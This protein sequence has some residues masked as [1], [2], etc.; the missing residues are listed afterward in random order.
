[1]KRRNV[2]K[3]RDLNLRKRWHRNLKGSNKIR[4]VRNR[5]KM[6]LME[7]LQKDKRHHRRKRDEIQIINTKKKR[8]AKSERNNHSKTKMMNT[9]LNKRISL[10]THP[11]TISQ[12]LFLKHHLSPRRRTLSMHLCQDYSTLIC[13]WKNSER[14]T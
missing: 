4:M 7:K 9:I 3:K 10:R 14:C 1:M 6:T 11:S 2:R 12:E 8:K 5:M 13:H